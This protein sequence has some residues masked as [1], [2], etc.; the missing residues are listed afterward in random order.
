MFK[1]LDKICSLRITQG[2][3]AMSKFKPRT[4][5]LGFY[6]P[7]AA[8]ME[9]FIKTRKHPTNWRTHQDLMYFIKD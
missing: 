5:I 8:L 9:H 1:G 3:Q 6:F 4:R 7:T 2:L